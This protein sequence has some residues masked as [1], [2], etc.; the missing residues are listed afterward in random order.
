MENHRNSQ[1]KEPTLIAQ[2]VSLHLS[3]LR[4]FSG[5]TMRFRLSGKE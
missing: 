2:A 5:V 3:F 1:K 4:A